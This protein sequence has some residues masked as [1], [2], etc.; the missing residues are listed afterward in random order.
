MHDLIDKTPRLFRVVNLDTK[1]VFNTF[2]KSKDEAVP[3]LPLSP[4]DTF[5]IEEVMATLPDG[6][7]HNIFQLR[8]VPA[9]CSG[10]FFCTVNCNNL[11]VGK[12]VWL[13]QKRDYDPSTRKYC[14]IAAED[15]CKS[16][17]FKPGQWVITTFTY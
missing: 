5:T 17:E 9:A 7:Q 10:T 14:C 11:K 3:S 4:S 13:K 2:A 6:S 12:T 16:R 15:I 1:E 8:H